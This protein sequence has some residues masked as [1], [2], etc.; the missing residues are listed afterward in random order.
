M[1]M[2]RLIAVT[3]AVL[4]GSTG[5]GSVPQ[6]PAQASGTVFKRLWS[7]EF[8]SKVPTKP[9]GRN[10][11]YDLTNGYGWGNGEEQYYTDSGRNIRVM[12]GNLNITALR[13]SD[14]DPILDSCFACTYTSARIKTAGKLG[15][16]YGRMVARI[17]LPEGEGTWPAFWMLGNDLLKGGTWP[18]AGEIDIVETRGSSPYV[19]HGTVHGPN[20]SGGNGVGSTFYALEPLSA[21]YHLYSIDWTP[22]KIVW[23][24]DNK[25]Y[26]TLTPSGVRGNR[27]VFNQE[28]FL[29]LNLAMG[30]TF[31]GD[32]N[33]AVKSAR[34]SV[35]WIRYY[36][37]NGLGRVYVKK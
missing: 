10:W 17:K 19:V 29:I 5:I 6:Q 2:K 18:D 4:I 7:E 13:L 11:D 12:G 23:S 22:N 8:N 30:G 27:W 24:F 36:S 34:M 28:Y 21:K 9:N 32:T 33:P 20:Y 25:P 31:G 3:V 26:F 37:I 15:F 1:K 16:R 14:M 35:D